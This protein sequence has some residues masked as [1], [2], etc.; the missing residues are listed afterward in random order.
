MLGKILQT[1]G[2]R[3]AFYYD[4]YAGYHTVVCFDFPLC[5]LVRMLPFV[6]D[7]GCSDNN[8]GSAGD[9][10]SQRACTGSVATK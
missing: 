9:D 3:M 6:S 4:G 8:N 5:T 1:V 7:N 2:E 10:M